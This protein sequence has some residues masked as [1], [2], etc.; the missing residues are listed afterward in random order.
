M[1]ILINNIDQFVDVFYKDFFEKNEEIANSF[2]NT[3]L[4]DQ[5]LELKK[6]LL[7]ILDNLNNSKVL[8]EYLEDLGVRH[9]SYEVHTWHYD[10]VRHS[11]LNAFKS[12][13][14]EDW[15]AET[16][17]KCLELINHICLMMMN[18]AEKFEDEKAG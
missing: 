7:F 15:N 14:G 1:N 17:K 11:L 9:V 12:I 10:N 4:K 18:G 5:K 3:D 16:E 8:N 13:H 2:R 6:G